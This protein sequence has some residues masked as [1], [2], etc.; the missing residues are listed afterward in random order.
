MRTT[1]LERGLDKRRKKK[2]HLLLLSKIKSK[3]LNV[4]KKKQTNRN[5]VKLFSLLI[6]RMELYIRVL[7]TR[8]FNF[9]LALSSRNKQNLLFYQYL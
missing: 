6:L 4:E 7:L 1:S 2:S 8:L 3:L 9:L 5:I